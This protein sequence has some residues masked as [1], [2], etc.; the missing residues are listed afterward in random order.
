[1]VDQNEEIRLLKGCINDLISVLALPAVWFGCESSQMAKTLLDGLVG[2]MR[3]DFAYV[4]LRE[5]I[6]GSPIE[7]VRLA[8]RKDLAAQPGEVGRMLE[9]WLKNDPHS[10]PLI[11]PNPVGEGE[12]SIAHLRLGLQDEVGS[13]VAGSRRADFPTKF[14]MLLLRVAANQAAMGLQEARLLSEQKR[15]AEELEQRVAERTIQLSAVNEELRKE[16]TERK[17]TEGLLR[18][19]NE[20]V[21][22][23]L[24]SITDKFFALD[25]EWRYTYFNTHAEEQLKSLGKDPASLIGKVLWD[26]FQNP[27]SEKELRRAMQERVVLTDEQYF[28]PLAEWYENRIYPTP[29]GGLAIYQRYITERKRAE[30]ELVALKNEIAAELKAM[31]RLHRFSTRLLATTELQPLLEE[32]LNATIALQ[33]ADFGI[34]QLYNPKTRELDI[35]AQVGFEQDSLDYF[36]NVHEDSSTWSRVMLRKE[37]VIIED[38]Q[39]DQDYEPRRRIAASAG[40]RAVQSTP[41]FSRNGETLGVI[42]T[43]FRQPHRPSDRE[44]RLTDLYAR[45]AA[46]M[47]ER[48]RVEAALQRSETYQAEAQRLSHTASWA[49]NVSTGDIFWSQEH[50]RIFGLDPE[51]VKPSYPSFLQYIH[52]EDRDSV[53]QNFDMSVRKNSDYEMDFRILLPDGTIKYI[54][55]LAHPAFNESGELIEYI[56]TIIDNTERKQIDEA[57]QKAQTELAHVSRV[58]TL[59]EMTASIAHEVNQPLGAIVTNGYACLRFLSRNSPDLDEAQEAVEAMISDGLR[60]SEVI[61]RI[62][63]LLKKS[64]PTKAPLDINETIQE[65]IVLAASEMAKNQIQLKTTLEADLPSVMGDRI[66]LQQVILNLVLNSKDAMSSAGWQPRNLL[67]SSEKTKPDEVM[68]AVQDTGTGL[69]PQTAE[70]IFDAFFSTKTSDGGL[71]LGLSISRTII[72][73]H[74]GKLWSTPN[75]GQGTTFQFTLPTSGENRGLSK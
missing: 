59:G 17:Q 55:S 71:G 72:E 54:H 48:K 52:R 14:E 29:D 13:I 20:K 25:S 40:F 31:N 64:A 75:N 12:I 61:K 16:I 65:V 45:Q 6:D 18:K 43:H 11:V 22:T 68:V 53:Q 58:T 74:R 3:L 50:F 23:I 19:V 1:V 39:T 56:G 30:A 73:A 34:I 46:E 62:R 38:V 27:T 57:L 36:S 21:E 5:R 70:R 67:I 26:E 9:A 35:V 51:K 28:P 49:W 41:L 24:D 8:D 2:M 4:R 32:A 60:A 37:R 44:L 7:L 42:S 69:D 15:D 33:N 63:G 10:S 66:Q 47:I